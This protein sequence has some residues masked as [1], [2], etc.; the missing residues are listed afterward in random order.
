MKRLAFF[1]LLLAAFSCG[2]KDSKESTSSNVL[3]N[4]SFTVDTILVNSGEELVDL[5][6]G[7][8]LADLSNDH[9]LLYLM[10]QKNKMLYIFDL[11]QKKLV[12]G[13]QFEIEGP[14]GV[15]EYPSSFQ[16]FEGERFLIS[17]YRSSL[18]FDKTAKRIGEFK[19][20]KDSIEG[21][22][23]TDEM[24][25]LHHVNLSPDEKWLFSLPGNFFEGSRD[26]LVYEVSKSSGK[27]LDIPAMDLAGDFRVVLQSKDMM[28]ISIEDVNFSWANNRLFVYSNATSDIYSYDYDQ[29]SLLLYTFQHTL[30]A[31]KKT[32]NI[33]HTVETE[34]AF[35]AE[36]EKIS[37]QITFG[38][39]IWDPASERYFRFGKIFVPK[40]EL[41][42]K[43]DDK[44]Y[45]F[46]YDKDLTLIGET[47]L[48]ELKK[49]PEKSF[50]KDGKLWS[51][52]NV[53]DELGFAVMDFK[54]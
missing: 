30:V 52:V 44:V 22:E 6:G 43:G 34:A 39:M 27:Q 50:F 1:T 49:Q 51:Y 41:E 32:G 14:N 5:S 11:E 54:F 33:Q 53:E 3:E 17:D 10:G 28:M 47:F 31:P 7:M 37:T 25:L 45:L 46:A 21:L 13:V 35:N 26:L 19:I 23:T 18:L 36:M 20:A 12:E 40:P 38:P 48:D 16:V 42:R 24:S 4:L 15:G 2:S 29:D 9:R 8:S